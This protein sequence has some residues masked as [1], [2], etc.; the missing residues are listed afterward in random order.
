MALTNQLSDIVKAS[1]KFLQSGGTVKRFT[2]PSKEEIDLILIQLNSEMGEPEALSNYKKWFIKSQIQL[3]LTTAL[4]ISSEI[5]RVDV[6]YSSDGKIASVQM[7]YEYRTPEESFY[8]N[9]GIWSPQEGLGAGT[10]LRNLCN[11]YATWSGLDFATSLYTQIPTSEEDVYKT[12]LTSSVEIHK[13]IEERASNF[14]TYDGAHWLTVKR[15]VLQQVLFEQRGNYANEDTTPLTFKL[16][17]GYPNIPD[18]DRIY[19]YDE[20]TKTWNPVL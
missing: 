9:D 19:Q 14:S 12:G 4:S 6:A 13:F 5:I 20:P 17:G 7:G 3:A 11:T 2:N 15:E 8:W 18:N 10:C 16:L 1:E